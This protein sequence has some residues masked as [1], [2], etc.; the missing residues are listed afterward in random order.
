MLR[1]KDLNYIFA[2]ILHKYGL[3]NHTIDSFNSC[4]TNGIRQIL[5]NIFKIDVTEK[6]NDPDIDSVNVIATFS[7]VNFSKPTRKDENNISRPLYPSEARRYGYN[8]SVSLIANIN[9]KATAFMK[10]G[11]TQI[12]EYTANS[13]NIASMPIMVGSVA[14]H[15]HGQSKAELVKLREDPRDPFGYFIIGSQEWIIGILETKPLNFVYCLRNMH[16]KEM[17]RLEIISKPGDAYE[18]SS[19]MVMT[20]LFSEGIVLNF[21][22]SDDFKHLR[23]PFYVM[24]RLLGMQHDKEIIDNVIGVEKKSLMNELETVIFNMLFNAFKASYDDFEEIYDCIDNISIFEKTCEIMAITK[25][26]IQNDTK[27]KEYQVYYTNNLMALIDKYVLPHIGGTKAARYSKARYICYQIRRIILTYLKVYPST[28]RDDHHNKRMHPAG[29]CY[30]KLFKRIINDS[31]V[32]KIKLNIRNKFRDSAF[33]TI[34]LESL[35]TGINPGDFE[36]NMTKAI[37]TGSKEI[38]TVNKDKINK[39]MKTMRVERKNELNV[40]ALLNSINSRSTTSQN[41]DERAYEMRDVHKSQCGGICI[42]QSNDTGPRVG[43]NKQ[44]TLASRISTSQNSYIVR[45]YLLKD[46]DIVATEDIHPYNYYKYTKIFVN[47]YPLGGTKNPLRVFTKYRELKRGW[48][49]DT[50]SRFNGTRPFDETTTIYWNMMYDEIHFWLDV[51]RLLKPVLIVRNNATE[52]GEVILGSSYDPINNT[53]FEQR[54]LFTQDHVY[55]I[56]NDMIDIN[57]LFKEGILEWLAPDEMYYSYLTLDINDIYDN[58][59]NA[60]KRYDYV[61]IAINLLGGPALTTPYGHCNNPSRNTFQTNQGK[62]SNG[63]PS[64]QFQYR[65]DAKIF[66]QIYNQLPLVLTIINRFV[67][68]NGSNALVSLVCA[69][70]NQEDSLIYNYSASR[71]GFNTALFY[72]VIVQKHEGREE[73]GRPSADI[74]KGLSYNFSKLDESG[75]IK[76]Y[77]MVEKGDVLLGVIKRSQSGDSYDVSDSVIYDKKEPGLIEDILANVEVLDKKK[78]YRATKIKASIVLEILEGDK[79]SSRHGQ[80]GCVS[81]IKDEVELPFTSNGIC[82]TIAVSSHAIPSRMTIGQLIEGL[83]GT[84]CAQEGTMR[85]GTIFSEVDYKPIL[86]RLEKVVHNKFA[87]VVMYNPVTGI[88]LDND[89]FLT[90]TY[91]QRLQKLAMSECNATDFARRSHITKQPVDGFGKGGSTRISEL[92]KDTFVAQ[93][94]IFT[95]LQKF[96][97]DSDGFEI[98]VCKTCGNM[99]IHNYKSNS[100]SCRTC[101]RNMMVSQI[102]KVRTSWSS[103]LWLQELQTLNIGTRLKTE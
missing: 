46:A 102:V 8:Y 24:L 65:M 50:K 20:L 77:S 41:Q 64:L 92:A 96:T 21:T 87:Y 18:N 78:Y 10:D 90:P 33:N 103:K 25:S 84:L 43:L 38:T 27:K 12:K 73:I 9:I 26:R 29:E 100:N 36:T 32:N 81:E 61:D 6:P 59:N 16:G 94:S 83:M 51:G 93:G 4:L 63:V 97:D 79:Y 88:F 69:D 85:D 14:C 58:A 13:I 23:M 54:V 11:T 98:Y 39:N 37:N 5:T 91:Y 82:A 57:D 68:P 15:L 101:D 70:N 28:D 7:D 19:E 48:D 53:G 34:K 3:T 56:R 30:A 66:L 99:A 1:N 86:D 55:A 60:L 67:I 22:S 49:L 75:I 95:L 62:Q 45:E 44:R 71:R 72:N 89:I 47:G 76:K 40:I 31:P 35:I 74:T 80:K 42:S 52:L 2:A 17:T